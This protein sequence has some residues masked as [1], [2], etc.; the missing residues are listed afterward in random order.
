M[1][2]NLIHV[3]YIIH[4]LKSILVHFPGPNYSKVRTTI[5][6]RHHCQEFT[7]Q[8]IAEYYKLTFDFYNLSVYHVVE[9]HLA[10][11]VLYICWAS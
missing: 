11:I 9:I 5:I 8:K 2:E 4:K 7:Y 3:F 1:L 6:Y 10:W